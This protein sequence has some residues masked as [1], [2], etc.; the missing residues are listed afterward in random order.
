MPT[1]SLI[2]FHAYPFKD[3][4]CH[5]L[6]AHHATCP[7]ISVSFATTNLPDNLCFCKLSGIFLFTSVSFF[8]IALAVAF[9][10]SSAVFVGLCELISSC[11]ATISLTLLFS[12]HS[13]LYPSWRILCLSPFHRGGYFWIYFSQTLRSCSKG[14]C[15][16]RLSMGM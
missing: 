2:L 7:G 5:F 9:I 14:W 10:T 4:F 8:L 6:C 12:C 13:C 3:L 11:N 16:R 1:C 15:V